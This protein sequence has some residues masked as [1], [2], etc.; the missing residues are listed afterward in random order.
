VIIGYPVFLS[1]VAGSVGGPTLPSGGGLGKKEG[2]APRSCGG[3]ILG[4]YSRM[5]A[6]ATA[7]EDHPLFGRRYATAFSSITTR[8]Q[9]VERARCKN[10]GHA[11]SLV[12][13]LEWS[14]ATKLT[15]HCFCWVDRSGQ[16]MLLVLTSKDF[17]RVLGP[18]L[19]AVLEQG[20]AILATS[21]REFHPGANLGHAKVNEASKVDLARSSK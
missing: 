14:Y 7:L 19:K 17:G 9:P 4:H 13:N 20:P 8:L 2:A 5:E 10:S 3:G 21:D 11:L 1:F 18:D 12:S 15:E 16:D 6:L